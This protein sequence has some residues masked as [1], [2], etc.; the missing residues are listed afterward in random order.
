M[1]V[2]SSEQ[3][4]GCLREMLSHEA[5][6]RL[7]SELNVDFMYEIRNGGA[8]QRFRANAYFQTRGLNAVF[9]VIPM[10]IPT[11]AEMGLPA[12]CARLT[13]FHQGLVLVT[14]PSGSG[15]TTTLAVL[16]DIINEQKPLHII[17]IEDPIEFIHHDKKALV[18][19]RQV[20]SHVVSF[21]HAL[22]AALREDPDVIIV[23]EL[24]DLETIRLAITASE[25]GHLVLGTLNTN[26]AAQT[27]DRIIDSFPGEQQAQ[28]RTMIAESL[29]GIVSQ[30]L[31]RK[32]DSSGRI[33]AVEILVATPSVSSLIR[34]GKTFQ[35]ISVMQMG[36]A[37]GMMMMDAH[38]HDLVM[39]G[40]VS[41]EEAMDHAFDRRT[42]QENLKKAG[43]QEDSRA[44]QS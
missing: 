39:N 38:L 3:I 41:P 35:L 18:I 15:K 14:G 2:L 1:E 23:G 6:T 29:R 10:K 9:R 20:G 17:T 44:E 36:R 24:R 16:T 25:T 13:D 31:L 40:Q 32:A 37:Q 28:I 30:Q 12:S 22:R 34:E 5:L 33:P 7:S 19:Q 27:I 4:E 11:L 8:P 21:P 43:V 26:S 42:F